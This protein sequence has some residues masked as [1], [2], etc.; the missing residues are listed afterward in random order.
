MRR[1]FFT[2]LELIIAVTIFMLISL[3]LFTFSHQVSESWSRLTVERNRFNELLAMDRAIDS[4]LT[5]AIPFMWKQVDNG[6]SS[7]IPFIVAEKDYLRIACLHPINDPQEGAIRFVEFVLEQGDLK[8]VYTDRPFAFWDEI[9]ED[10]RST[11]I[12][13]TEVAS[14]E[15]EYADW[16][17][18]VSVDWS[19]RL[20]WRTEWLED[21][22]TDTDTDTDSDSNNASQARSDIP[23]AIRMTVT[24]EDGRQESWLRRTMGNSYRERYGTYKLPQDNIP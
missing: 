21:T 15:F 20:L 7:E 11:T 3:A 2:F 10:R 4:I 1:R 8:A 22:D 18:D 23:L 12:L 6:I 9:D 5:N 14:L 16:S 19:E 13:S 17:S 24:W